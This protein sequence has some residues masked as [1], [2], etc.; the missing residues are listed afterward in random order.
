ML[1]GVR[2]DL[3]E[4]YRRSLDHATGPGAMLDGAH[5]RRIAQVAIDAFADPAP[6][7]PWARP[8]ADPIL[9]ATVRVARHAGTLTRG[10]YDAL[11]HGGVDELT[12]VEVVGVVVAALPPFAFARAAGCPLPPLPVAAP[13]RPHGR[14]APVIEPAAW[15]WVPV[16]APADVRPAVVQALSAL[17]DEWDNMWRLAAAQYMADE[18]MV[19]P[20]WTRGTLSRPQMELVATRLALRRECFY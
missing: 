7:P 15:N 1:V 5:R 14:V 2:E 19:D 10:W 20:G 6:D 3:V 4:A 12:W 17:P 13:G 8:H 9:D 11:V 16:S 18:E